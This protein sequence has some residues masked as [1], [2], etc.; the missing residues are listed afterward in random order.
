MYGRVIFSSDQSKWGHELQ[1]GRISRNKVERLKAAL[2]HTGIFELKGNCYL[3]RDLPVDCVMVDLGTR[4]RS[5]GNPEI[6]DGRRPQ[7]CGYPE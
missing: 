4:K 2:G 6:R 1:H 7:R 3:G 5:T